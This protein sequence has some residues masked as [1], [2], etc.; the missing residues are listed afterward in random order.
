[1]DVSAKCKI[2][3]FNE[4]FGSFHLILTFTDVQ[5][6]FRPLGHWAFSALFQMQWQAFF[7]LMFVLLAARLT[8]MKRCLEI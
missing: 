8:N 4:I 3:Y 5:Q 7:K 1:M 2:I 6:S